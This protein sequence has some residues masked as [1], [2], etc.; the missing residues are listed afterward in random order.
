M[1]KTTVFSSTQTK[2]IINWPL[3]SRCLIPAKYIPTWPGDG[4]SARRDPGNFSF[5]IQEGSKLL[6]E[7]EKIEISPGLC[8]HPRTQSQNRASHPWPVQ[9]L[10]PCVDN[11]VNLLKLQTA[12]ATSFRLLKNCFSPPWR[13]PGPSRCLSH[14]LLLRLSLVLVTVVLEPDLHLQQ[15]VSVLPPLCFYFWSF[16]WVW[17]GLVWFG[18][19]WWGSG[20]SSTDTSTHGREKEMGNRANLDLSFKYILLQKE[21]QIYSS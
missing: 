5:R 10:Q 12:K 4:W 11:G 3:P 17:F 18:L 20:S 16:C 7:N 19:F 2:S 8:P 1:Y 15:K 6:N 13:R 21:F 14:C 9:A